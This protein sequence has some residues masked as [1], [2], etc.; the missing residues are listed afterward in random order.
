MEV[1]GMTDGVE[2]ESRLVFLMRSF[3][4]VENHQKFL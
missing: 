2:K 1:W 4:R 3:C